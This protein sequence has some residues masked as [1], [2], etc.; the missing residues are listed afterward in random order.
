MLS[1]VENQTEAEPIPYVNRTF[2]IPAKRAR[3]LD[4]YCFI[5]GLHKSKVVDQGI[6]LVL[7][8]ANFDP[9]N[10]QFSL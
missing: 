8:H 1:N 6:E 2:R 5:K 10:I 4:A 9:H 3:E 7:K